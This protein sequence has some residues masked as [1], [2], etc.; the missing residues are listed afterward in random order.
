MIFKRA[1]RASTNNN[2]LP[3]AIGRQGILLSVRQNREPQRTLPA[4]QAFSSVS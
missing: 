3:T 1:P 2:A 4:F